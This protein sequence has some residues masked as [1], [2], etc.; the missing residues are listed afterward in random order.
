M[1]L[2]VISYAIITWFVNI[3]ADAAEGI[4]TSFLVEH[5][6]AQRYQNMSF[7]H[8][9]IVN[10]SSISETKLLAELTVTRPSLTGTVE[11]K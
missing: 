3:D 8:P 10:L 5:S 2:V 9:V 7:A 4:C 1:I 11:A 6:K